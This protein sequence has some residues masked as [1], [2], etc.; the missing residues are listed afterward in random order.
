MRRR[1]KGVLR[2]RRGN[3]EGEGGTKKEKGV[4]RMRRGNV[5][6]GGGT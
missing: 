1:R 2:R 5:E 3:V 4:R 6:G